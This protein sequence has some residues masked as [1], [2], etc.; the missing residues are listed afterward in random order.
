M[1]FGNMEMAKFILSQDFK[2]RPDGKLKKV[3]MTDEKRKELTKERVKLNE[4]KEK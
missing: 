4:D 3:E 2:R 1:F